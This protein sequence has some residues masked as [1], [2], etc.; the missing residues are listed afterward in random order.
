L[1]HTCRLFDFIKSSRKGIEFNAKIKSL[2]SILSSIF[3]HVP[4]FVKKSF[5]EQEESSS[6]TSGNTQRFLT[7]SRAYD[8]E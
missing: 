4:I 1:N 3:Y 8:E 6:V 5:P 2:L 7:L